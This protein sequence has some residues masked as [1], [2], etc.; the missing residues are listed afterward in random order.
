MRLEYIKNKVNVI[1]RNTIFS[2]FWYKIHESVKFFDFYAPYEIYLSHLQTRIQLMLNICFIWQKNKNKNYNFKLFDALLFVFYS[3]YLSLDMH[4]KK[5]ILRKYW[6]HPLS[7][8]L[9]FYL[10]KIQKNAIFWIS[11]LNV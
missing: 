8:T 5:K 9:D 2:C 3:N 10:S 7:S 1:I 4:L 6:H 11:I